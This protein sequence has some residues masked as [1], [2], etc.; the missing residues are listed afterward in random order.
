MNILNN[1]LEEIKGDNRKVIINVY[2]EELSKAIEELSKNEDFFKLPLNNIFSI[3]SKVDFNL[4]EESDKIIEIIQNIIKNIIKVHSDEKETILILQNLNTKTISFSSIDEI[5]SI[6]ELITNCPI[7]VNFCHLYKEQNKDVDIDYEYEL[8]QKDK[9]IAKLKEGIH[10]P[11]LPS[12]KDIHDESEPII[13]KV[14][15]EGNLTCFKWLLEKEGIDL[16]KTEELNDDNP[17][18][19]ASKYGHLSIVQYLIKNIK[20][21][22]DIKGC[23]GKSPLHYACENGHLHVVEYLIYMD[24]NIEAKDKEGKTPLHYVCSN[25]NFEIVEYLISQD[26]DIEAKDYMGKTPLYYACNNCHTLII[27]YLLSKG[28]K[29][30]VQ[31]DYNEETP[32]HDACNKGDLPMVEYLILKGADIEATND[33][34]RTP[35]HCACEKGHL[36]IV[37]FL[38]FK[39]ANIEAKDE[40]NETPLHVASYRLRYNICKFLLSKRANRRAMNKYGQRPYLG[41]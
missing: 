2:E 23:Y 4:Q 7:L 25:G 11:I 17:I 38:V 12:L 5:F 14:C 3:L 27:D 18:H 15:R 29:I 36:P 1:Y 39:G 33:K 26:A 41:F 31:G 40:I 8:Q 13:F 20:V 24:A 28:A 37:E 16:S 21:D 9:E 6:L 35:L 34:C 32:L 10:K 30:D 22:K 19:I